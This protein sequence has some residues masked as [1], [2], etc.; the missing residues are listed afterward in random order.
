M[1][2]LV[3]KEEKKRNIVQ[4]AIKVFSRSGFV[5]T[6]MA[7]IALEAGIGKGTIYEY[8]K[9]KE[10]LF[11]A[12]CV[13]ILTNFEIQINELLQQEQD[14]VKK[15]RLVIEKSYILFVEES[16]EFA[17][18]MLD[19]WAEGVRSKNPDILKTLDL[20]SIY[21]DFRHLFSGI[22]E[23]GIQQGRIKPINTQV[24][25][26]TLIAL[27]DG[28]FLQWLVDRDVFDLHEAYTMSLSSLLEGILV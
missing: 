25:A 12:A 16:S 14:P 27:L 20:G 23:E 5:T 28:I 24:I 2:K 19:L 13:S 6:K 4:A 11:N 22:L 7:D 1:P 26:S 17:E 21:R 10:E 9:S 8:Y 18:F 15:L 3:N